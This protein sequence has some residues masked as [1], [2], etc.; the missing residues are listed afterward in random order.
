MASNRGVSRGPRGLK[1]LRGRQGVSGIRGLKGEKG[2][3]SSSKGERGQQGYRGRQGKAGRQYTYIQLLIMPV[4][5]V[6]AFALLTWRTEVNNNAIKKDLYVQCLQTNT[7]TVNVN[8]AWDNL[9][10]IEKNNPT[11]DPTLKAQQEAAYAQARQPLLV[12]VKP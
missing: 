11:I 4:F 3:L 2:D 5:I 1:G 8:A 6:L 7:D 12:C 9:A 10:T